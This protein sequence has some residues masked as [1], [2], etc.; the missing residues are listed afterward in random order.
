MDMEQWARVRRKILIVKRSKRSVMKEE[1]LHWETLQKMLAHSVP[2]GYRRTKKPE[3]KIDAYRDWIA[4]ILKSDMKVP[5][6]QR[7]SAKRIWERLREEHDFDGGYTVVKE[8]VVELKILKQE[9]FVP[10]IHRPGE[11][12]V[13][14]GHA[15]VNVDGLLSKRSF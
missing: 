12:Q 13:D 2:P 14:F 8:A 4:E 11:A 9:V 10:L 6:K 1:D 3:R 7:H 15:L 5:R